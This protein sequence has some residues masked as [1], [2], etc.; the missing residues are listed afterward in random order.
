MLMA[1]F[2]AA[3]VSAAPFTLTSSG[4]ANGA[5]M[6]ARFEYSGDGCTGQNQSP[7]LRWS[8]AP[9]GTKS[10]A[11][12]VHDPDAPVSGGFWHWVVFDIPASASALAAS[13]GSGDLSTAPRGAIQGTTS[14]GSTGYSGPCPPRRG[15]THHYVFTLFALDE[16]HLA[17]ATSALDGPRLTALLASHTL[18]KATLIGLFSRP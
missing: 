17:G 18:A 7:P 12:T 4:F 3:S 16:D 15:G 14:F 5:V 8:N 2:V 9:A 13:A 6:S 11:L 10:Y 1:T